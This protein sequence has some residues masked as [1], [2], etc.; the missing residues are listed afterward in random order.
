MRLSLKFIVFLLCILASGTSG[1]APLLSGHAESQ[2]PKQPSEANKPSQPAQL[3]NPLMQ[4]LPPNA[5][6]P[7]KPSIDADGFI[8]AYGAKDV[9]GHFRFSDLPRPPRL[10]NMLILNGISADVRAVM[11]RRSVCGA[12][13]YQVLTVPGKKDGELLGITHGCDGSCIGIVDTK[14]KEDLAPGVSLPGGLCRSLWGGAIKLEDAHG[15]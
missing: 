2:P 1:G 6:K 14:K 9:D 15:L 10:L 11:Y 5:S 8:S 12:R 13:A 3:S 7:T 4:P